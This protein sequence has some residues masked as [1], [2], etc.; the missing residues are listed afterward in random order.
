MVRGVSLKRRIC[1]KT[2]Q[3]R[4]AVANRYAC[5][6][7]GPPAIANGLSPTAETAKVK[8]FQEIAFAFP[9]GSHQE[10]FIEGILEYAR[11]HQRKWSYMIAPESNS[12]SITQLVGWPGDGVIAALNTPAE[13][14]CAEGFHLPVVNISSA[15]RRSPIPRTMVDNRQIGIAAAEHFL[16]RGYENYAFYGMKGIEYSAQR[17]EGLAETVAKNGLQVRTHLASPTF[18]V[19]GSHWLG[20]QKELT[21]WVAKLPAPCAVLAASDA[22]ARQ[23]MNSCRELRLHVPDQIAV[24]GVD[25]QQIIC[26]HTHPTISSI[27][28]NNIAE[29]YAAARILDQLIEGVYDEN[30]DHEELVPPHGVA[31]RESTDIVAI[32]DDRLR[33]ALVYFQQNIEE[34]VTV[35]ELCAHS[36]VSRRWLEY[37]F[38]DLLGESPFHYIRRQR[39]K[40]AKRLLREERSAAINVVARR[41]GYS[42]SNQLAKAF[43]AEFGMSPREYRRTIDRSPEHRDA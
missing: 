42:S 27:A 37:A 11:D 17:L 18:R 16:E 7:T 10:V 39:L 30:Q 5:D 15:L 25:D 13:A 9:R 20:Q 36:G 33:S 23:V 8:P 19:R 1:K 28:R 3:V 24:L 2:L 41:T 6:W 40:H 22:R 29:G 4:N 21:K 32:S 35:S 31:M 43:R 12:V 14:K 38:R 26:E 34:P